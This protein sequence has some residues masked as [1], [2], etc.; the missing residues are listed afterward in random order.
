MPGIYLPPGVWL[1]RG[2]VLDACSQGR[3]L[4]LAAYEHTG[5]EDPNITAGNMLA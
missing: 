4:D 5:E 1:L 2:E 3:A